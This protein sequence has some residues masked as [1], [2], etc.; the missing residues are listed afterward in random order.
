MVDAIVWTEGKT[1]GQYLRRACDVLEFKYKVDLP[2]S[3]DMGDD[4]LL[5]QC[6]ALAKAP[7]AKP[8]IFIF[9]SDNSEI[10]SKVTAGENPYKSWGNNV[11]SFAIPAPEHRDDSAICME[12]LFTD[13]D[14]RKADH[15]GRRVFL[16]S[17]FNATSGRHLSEPTLSVGHKGKLTQGKVRSRIIDTEVYDNNH[18]NVAL[19]KADF[20][21]LVA[22][23]E[24]AFANIDFRSFEKILGTME[25]IIRSQTFDLLFGGKEKFLTQLAELSKHEQLALVV[26]ASV[27]LCKL[28][29][30]LFAAIT[31]RYYDQANID[32]VGI[33]QKKLRPVRQT[34]IENFASPSLSTLVRTA[35]ACFHLIDDQAPQLLQNLRSM[36]AENPV[37]GPIGDLLDDLERL[38][39][40]DGSR[41]RVIIKR[42]SK[43]QLLEYVFAELAKYEARVAEIRNSEA[44]ALDFADEAIWT[45]AL[46]MLV[47]LFEPLQHTVFRAGNI[48][49]LQADSDKFVLQLTTYR[50]GRA[51]TEEVYRDYADL[52]GDR[53]ETYEIEISQ[54]S[55]ARWLDVSPFAIIREQQLYVYA[56]TRAVG[57]QYNPLFESSVHIVPTKRRFGHAA[58]GGSI[59]ADRQ[60]LFWTRVA[61]AVSGAGVRANIP[62]HDP[63]DFVGRKQQLAT[64]MDEII[65]I[66]N[67]NGLLHGPGGVGKTAL[68][69]ELSRKLFEEGLPA[70]APF[71][72]IIWVSAKR[73]YYDPTLNVIEAGAQQFKTLDQVFV[74]ILE[75]HEFEEP[76][77]YS[78]DEQKWLVLELFEEQKTLLILDNFET[79]SQS[80][81]SEI[82]RFFG[83]ELKR[84]LIHK[85]DNSKILLTSREVIPSGFHQIQLKGLD[86]RESVSLMQRL[87]QPYAQ[88]GQAQLADGKRS[89]LYEATRGIPLIIKHCYGQVFEYNMPLDSVI[90]SLLSAGN[91]VVEFSFAEIFKI[92]RED[93]LQRKIIVLL[94]VIKRPILIRQMADILSVEQWSI[95]SRIGNLMNFQCIVRSSSEA[96]DKYAINPEVRLLAARLAHDSIELADIIR[97]DI[98]KLSGEK[99]IDYNQEELDSIVVFQ[100]YLADGRLA[101]AE[102]CIRELL[103]KKPDS[104]F[105][106]LHYAEY[107]KEQKRQPLEAI[108]RLERI[109]VSSGNDPQVLRLLMMYNIALEPPN[110]DEAYIFAK[111]LEK[112]P[113]N[114][115]E[116]VMDLA[117]FYTEWATTLK[118]RIELDPIKE[119]LRQQKYKELSDHAVSLLRRD[120]VE[121]SHRRSYLLAQCLFN[122]WDYSAAKSNIDEAIQSLP[123]NSYLI[124]PYEKLRGEINRKARHYQRRS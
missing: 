61:P 73:D 19:S 62:P 74:A 27:R 106:N 90:K 42:N 16:S 101:Q 83:T 30:M 7:Q 22:S 20:A 115:A 121:R 24:G 54:A 1:D 60:L 92:L 81:Q 84:H 35:R 47:S 5:K 48:V 63:T 43:K 39:P 88:S 64:I 25:L 36:M 32:G 10:V 99:R 96:D 46:A 107:L 113:R 59:S 120:V 2:V 109:R 49:R 98:A 53:L 51:V 94:E 122:K 37:L 58:L 34:I 44:D 97:H 3:T 12:L 95:E 114:E 93:E 80:A 31:V 78:R 104:V 57:Y 23:G 18:K 85:P 66:P 21:S 45:K 100:R 124:A 26:D 86:K 79:I 116:A 118:L 52:S 28:G 55:G 76:E 71:R 110:F 6:S 33:D 11:F 38:L 70:S 102:D 75:F 123:E 14:L 119:M 29:A 72:N 112:Y 68:L 9:D 89:Q 8:A 50:D 117:Q 111:E 82:I 77:Q 41:G 4:A 40:I 56:R 15:L 91:N 17:E 67:E 103:K 13:D 69:I 87:Y 105:F 108:S 65:Q